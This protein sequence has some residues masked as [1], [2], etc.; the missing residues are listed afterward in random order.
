MAHAPDRPVQYIPRGVQTAR[1]LTVLSGASEVTLSGT[2]TLFSASDPPTTVSTGAFSAN[3]YTFTPAADL[4]IG[5][6]YVERWTY[7][8]GSNTRIVDRAVV[9]TRGLDSQ[10]LL[11]DHN[12]VIAHHPVL[13]PPNL[14]AGYTSWEVQC[15]AGTREI[16]RILYERSAVGLG[17]ADLIDAGTLAYPALYCT[18]RI[19]GRTGAL[20]GSEMFQRMADDADAE[21]TAWLRRM[22]LDFDTDGDTHADRT[23]T[24]GNEAAGHPSASPVRI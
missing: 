17:S 24:L 3:T 9:I 13:A 1:T 11:T 19:I 15:V 22:K 6:G 10:T 12:S 7:T 2:Y 14:P 4:P 16:L 21:L 20:T 5:R 8:D 18:L 23:D